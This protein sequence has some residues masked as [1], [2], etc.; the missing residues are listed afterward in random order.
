[1]RNMPPHWEHACTSS[2]LDSLAL[3]PFPRDYW[4]NVTFQY[5]LSDG[6]STT[7]PNATVT[8]TVSPPP[9]PPVAVNDSYNGVF[10]QPFSPSTANQLL[11]YND[12]STTGGAL[13]VGIVTALSPQAG[14]LTV[15]SNGNFTFSPAFG[16]SGAYV[17]EC[18]GL[19]QAC[20]QVTR[21]LTIKVAKH[22]YNKSN[23]WR[24]QLSWTGTTT[25]SYNMTDN[26][27][28]SS[29]AYVT[30]MI[31]PMTPI[32]ADDAYPCSYNATLIVGAANG[33]LNNDLSDNAGANLTVVTAA[34]QQPANGSVSIAA[35]GS[36]TLT[37]EL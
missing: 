20:T 11:L 7:H 33:V 30:M 1:M 37:P 13:V 16:W 27:N 24:S 10:G 25:W 18:F 21:A 15:T 19:H 34:T 31:P 36:F 22:M 28:Y 32:A 8:I 14:N 5:S 23:A 35:D 26:S 2:Q 3:D 29:V 6:V 4:G 17:N 12:N 9:T